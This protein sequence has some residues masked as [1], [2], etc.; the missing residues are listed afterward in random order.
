MDSLT[1]ADI[2]RTAGTSLIGRRVVYRRSVGSTNELAGELAAAGAEE[3]TLVLAD[4]QTAGRGRLGR[5]WLAPAGSSLLLSLLFRPSWTP[6]QAV[7]LTMI[8]SLAAAEAIEEQTGLHVNLKWP[9]DVMID[10]KKVGGVLTELSVIGGVLDYAVVGV[11][12][13]VNFDPSLTPQLSD[14]ATSLLRESGRPVSRL[15]LLAALLGQVESNYGRALAGWMPHQAWSA[16]LETLGRWVQ[17]V[18]PN[19]QEEGLAETV[20]ADGALLIRR[21]DGRPVRVLAGDVTLRPSLARSMP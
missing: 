10:G 18:T 9:N 14:S 15:S 7:R 11:G 17:V 6:P 4:E 13:N 16:R 5:S 21:S 1:A 20:D 19:G 2:R 8:C 3:G 12:L